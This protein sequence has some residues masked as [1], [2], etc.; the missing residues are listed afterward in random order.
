MCPAAAPLWP[1][2][3]AKGSA[4]AAGKSGRAVSPAFRADSDLRSCEKREFA[5]AGRVIPLRPTALALCYP[6]LA[7]GQ[8]CSAALRFNPSP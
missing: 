8:G 5:C 2:L 4:L 6:G 1:G 3:F 7:D